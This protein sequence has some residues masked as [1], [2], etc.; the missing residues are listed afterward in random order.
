MNKKILV[1]SGFHNASSFIT[2][3]ISKYLNKE[4]LNL[5]DKKNE[6]IEDCI[7]KTHNDPKDYLAYLNNWDIIIIPFRKKSK[8]LQSGYFQ[9]TNF[10]INTSLDI[11]KYKHWL[12][13]QQDKFVF[14]YDYVLNIVKHFSLKLDFSVKCYNIFNINQKCIIII[15]TQNN[16]PEEFFEE[17]YKIYYDRDF[18]KSIN[19]VNNRINISINNIIN[20]LKRDNKEITNSMYNKLNSFKEIIFELNQDYGYDDIY[21]K[22]LKNT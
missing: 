2:I 7:I 6:N 8:V 3:R 10:N 18:D 19:I 17:I 21:Y 4:P 1:F 15:D 5:W 13:D 20:Y 16:I 9:D 22:I 14:N 11:D 12:N